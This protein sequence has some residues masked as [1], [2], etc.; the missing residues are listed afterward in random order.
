MTLEMEP[1]SSQKTRW[2]KRGQHILAQ[3]TESAVIVYQAD[4]PAI[5]HFAARH[6]RCGG[7]SSLL[8]LCLLINK[9]VSRVNVTTPSQRVP[10]LVIPRVTPG[11]RGASVIG[12]ALVCLPLPRRQG[13]PH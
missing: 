6:K 7:E 13:A 8:S 1:Y 11:T 12:E 4:S 10:L 5:G 9:R 3:F 2:P